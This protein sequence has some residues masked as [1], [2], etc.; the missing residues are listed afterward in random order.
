MP[1]HASFHICAGLHVRCSCLRVR[2]FTDRPPPL[3]Y[4]LL[5]AYLFC[6]WI[7]KVLEIHPKNK[8]VTNNLIANGPVLC[9]SFLSLGLSKTVIF[10]FKIKFIVFSFRDYGFGTA[11]RKVLLTSRPKFFFSPDLFRDFFLKFLHFASGS[12]AP[13]SVLYVASN[14]SRLIYFV[15]GSPMAPTQPLGA[16]ILG[17][18]SELRESM[19][20]PRMERFLPSP[21]VASL[22]P[23]CLLRCSS[24]LQQLLLTATSLARVQIWKPGSCQS[25]ARRDFRIVLSWH[26]WAGQVCVFRS[27]QQYANL[28]EDSSYTSFSQI[29]LLAFRIIYYNN[30]CF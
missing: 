25:L 8:S 9:F 29:G 13:C 21:Y 26:M 23:G 6:Y 18:F 7:L 15:Q 4:H 14:K 10:I 22:L 12:V 11:S 3:G 27:S 17:S 20:F 16:I 24:L 2:L 1:P 30:W 5:S 19:A 28:L